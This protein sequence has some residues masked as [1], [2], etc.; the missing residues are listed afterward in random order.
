MKITARGSQVYTVA[1]SSPA[2]YTVDLRDHGWN[3]SCTCPTFTGCCL[4][5]LQ[6]QRGAKRWRCDHI[7]Q[8]RA[9]FTEH[10]LPAL[11]ERTDK[12][13]ELTQNELSTALPNRG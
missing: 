3:G 5:L 11:I 13:I 4:P 12:I 9:Y 1:D 7:L 10:E 2:T 6:A 8:C